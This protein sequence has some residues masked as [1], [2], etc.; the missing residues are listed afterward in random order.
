MNKGPFRPLFYMF[1]ITASNAATTAA[2]AAIITGPLVVAHAAAWRIRV[3]ARVSKVLGQS[4]VGMAIAWPRA[5][6]VMRVRW[7]GGCWV[8]GQGRHANCS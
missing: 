6:H 4:R 8:L 2:S 1:R 5:A 3:L 7:S